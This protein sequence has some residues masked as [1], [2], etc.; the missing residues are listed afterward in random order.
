MLKMRREKLPKFNIPI[1][2]NQKL[3]KLISKIENNKVLNTILRI[4]NINAI[5][6]LGYSDH[7]PVHV[8][9]VANLALE[10][11]RILIRR[12]IRPSI[13]ENYGLTNKDAEIVVVTGA[14]LHDIGMAINRPGHEIL[15]TL[16]ASS[17]IDYLIKDIYKSEEKRTIVKYEILHTIY[18]HRA[19]IKPLTIEAGIVKVADAL[20]MEK[21]RARIPYQIGMINIHSVS[22]LAIEKVKISDGKEKP[23]QIIILMS[24]PAGIFQ[25]DEL[26]K[27][28]IM[29]SGLEKMLEIEARI[30][31]E[32]K[33]EI[34]KKY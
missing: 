18:A 15:S 27:E 5:D 14:I 16:L 7:G 22:A 20:D 12:G 13:V 11:L 9:I 33:E 28:K 2:G 4:S 10:M 3:K 25:V 21:G 30:I 32:G 17:F 23:L 26:L 24:N 6:R 34:F 29:T 19:G 8:K 31:K 1:E